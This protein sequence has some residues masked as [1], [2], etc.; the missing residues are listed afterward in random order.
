MALNPAGL[1]A[2]SNTNNNVTLV[3][4][5]IG[6]QPAPCTP[7]NDNFANAIN[8]SATPF[9]A[10]QATDCATK[11]AGEPNHAG[12]AGGFSIWYKWT[13]TSNHTAVITTKGSDFDTTLGVYT[14]NSVSSLNLVASND[15]IIFG[16]YQQS[17]VSFPANGDD[18][19]HRGGWL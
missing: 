8:I 2:E 6:S 17:Y 10:S 7:V 4:V 3:P 15:D 18:I 5:T 14:G 9:S 1:I 11:E 19:S 16:T 13:P 12:N